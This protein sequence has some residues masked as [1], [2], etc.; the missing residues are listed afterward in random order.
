MAL[1][2]SDLPKLIELLNQIDIRVQVRRRTAAEWAAND[3]VL[4]PGEWG[5]VTDT[6]V[7]KQG[8]GVTAFSGLMPLP[9][10]LADPGADRL[11]FWDASAGMYQHVALGSGLSISDTTISSTGSGGSGGPDLSAEA[12]QTWD[13][14]D[15]VQVSSALGT[16]FVTNASVPVAYIDSGG[17]SGAAIISSEVSACGICRLTAASVGG[18]SRLFFSSPRVKFGT[19]ELQF[20]TRIRVPTLSDAVNRFNILGGYC[21]IINGV[22]I[23]R[24]QAL[25]EDDINGGNWVLRCTDGSGTTDVNTTVS[26]AA[27]AWVDL[28]LSINAAGTSASL[29]I[30][31]MGTPAATVTT[32]IPTVALAPGVW[33]GKT[34]NASSRYCDVDYGRHAQIFT[35]PR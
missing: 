25:Y 5:K 29:Y 24:L 4:L 15:G 23:Q 30:D 28:R 31:D 26:L 6:G 1:T 34:V 32:N 17:G 14:L 18:Y 27:N 12:S 22:G 8:N 13:F 7:M 2:N 35:T 9:G 19:D 11:L 3:E 33:I 20:D 21:N 16:S 10:V